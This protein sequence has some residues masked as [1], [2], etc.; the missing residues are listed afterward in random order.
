VTDSGNPL[1]YWRRGNWYIEMQYRCYHHFSTFHLSER[2]NMTPKKTGWLIAALL[3]MTMGP[4]HSAPPTAAKAVMIDSSAAALAATN[5]VAITSVMVSFQTSAGGEKTNTSGLFAAKTD[6]SSSLQMPEMDTKLLADIADE[7]YK[8]L[9]TDL[10]A[11]GFEVL[12]EDMVV[13]SSGYQ[14]IAKMAGISNFSKFANLDGDVLLVGATGLKPYLPYN[15]ETGKFNAQLKSQIKGW[16]EGFG[17]KSSTEGGPSGISI[18][19]IYGLP[20]LEVELA[21]ELNANLVKAT[22]VVTLGSTKAAVDRF[23]STS[24]NTYTGSAFAQVGLR[25][26][27]TRIAFRTPSA[28]PKGE[29]APGG[30]SANFGNSASPA[31]DGNVVASL[32]EPLMGGTDFFA[33]TEPETKKSSLLGGLLGG[34]FG[35]GADVQFTFIA[36]VSDAAAYR[37]EVVSM[38]KLAQQGMLAQIKQ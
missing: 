35:N 31:K 20:G 8:Q 3:S 12:A 18:A 28:N 24:H 34:G 6:S 33:V 23:S 14:K 9:K 32:G 15:V 36:S 21:K 29:S 2:I 19:E 4:V 37:A 16:I 30:Y 7:I 27:Q 25:A 26:G 38:A 13:A 22:Y 11:N 1:C 5:R 17:Q 10:A